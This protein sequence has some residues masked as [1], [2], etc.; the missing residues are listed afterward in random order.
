MTSMPF[1]HD[2]SRAHFRLAQALIWLTPALWAVNFIVARKAPGVIG[3]YTLAFGRWAVAGLLLVAGARAELWR[4]RA[5]IARVWYQYLGLGVCG[6]LVCGAWVYQGARTTGA[7]NIALIY[8]ASPVLIALGAVYWLGERFTRQQI[9]GALLALAGVVH[10]VVKGRWNAL[11][12]VQWVAGDGW[13]VLAM[14]SWAL[15]ALL[16]KLWPSSLSS[17]ARLAAICIGGVVSL[18]PFTVWELCQADVP[19]WTLQATWQVLAVALLPGVGAYWIYGWSQRL[20][21]ASRVAVTL[22]LGPL[23]AALAAWGVLGEPLGWHHLSGAALILP[24]VYWVTRGG[25]RS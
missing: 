17:T 9:V 21:G 10:V 24:G 5:A 3:P 16:Q 20:L 4:E 2:S 15:Y 14:V 11:G 7:L 6:M 19:P 23:Y 8:S 13:I 18:V 22:Y 25:A 12:S 1:P